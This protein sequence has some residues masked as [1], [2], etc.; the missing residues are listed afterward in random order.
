MNENTKSRGM[1]ITSLVLGLLS[2]VCFGILTGIPAIIC[3][4]LAYNRTRKVPERYNGAGMAI[5]GF[6]L[7]YASILTT[8]V[9]LAILLPALAQT[10]GKTLSGL[11]EARERAQS[12]SCINN[13]KQVGLAF[14]VYA[15]GHG[16]R[17]PF[18]VPSQE[19]GIM[20]LSGTGAE[21]F[22]RDAA[23][24][25]QVLSNELGSPKVLVCPADSSKTSAPDFQ[26]LLAANVSYL[27]RSGTNVDEINPSEVL[28]RCPIHGTQVLCDGSVH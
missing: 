23:R 24:I 8:F 27:V 6:I 5:A 19:G 17:F 12:I 28:A 25:F 9:I 21:G 4:H 1:A 16:D 22:D 2:M 3:G 13:M 26:H 7:G 14:R 15:T 20:E 18:N 11:A 10:K